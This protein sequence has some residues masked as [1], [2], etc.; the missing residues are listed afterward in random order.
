MVANRFTL[1]PA[2]DS[3]ISPGIG[4]DGQPIDDKGPGGGLPSGGNAAVVSALGVAS[5]STKGGVPGTAGSTT[6]TPSSPSRSA[7]MREVHPSFPWLLRETPVLPISRNDLLALAAGDA[8]VYPSSHISP[9]TLALSS[10]YH[11]W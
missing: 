6:P 9:L 10:C 3:E 11:C 4:A 5:E 2:T 1:S 8:P 7:L